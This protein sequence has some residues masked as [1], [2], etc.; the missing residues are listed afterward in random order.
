MTCDLYACVGNV[1]MYIWNIKYLSVS[2]ELIPPFLSFFFVFMGTCSQALPDEHIPGRCGSHVPSHSHESQCVELR[3]DGGRTP[4]PA[5]H[6]RAGHNR[7]KL[8]AMSL[9]IPGTHNTSL[10]SL[11]TNTDVQV[12]LAPRQGEHERKVSTVQAD[13]QPTELQLH[14]T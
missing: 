5:V 2:T 13:I 1:N 8:Q 12:L 4:V 7:Q 14:S 6:G 11:T 10:H 3:C 9:W